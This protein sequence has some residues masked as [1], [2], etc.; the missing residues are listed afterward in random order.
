MPRTASHIAAAA[1]FA[2]AALG[3]AAPVTSAT[4]PAFGY[5]RTE[6]GNAIVEIAACETGACGEMVWLDKP[7]DESGALKRDADGR[8]LCG[9]ELVSGLKRAGHGV[10]EEG[11]ILDPRSGQRYAAEIAVIASDK[12]NVRGYVLSS[13]FGASQVWT[14]AMGD[15]GGC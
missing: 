4:D 12:L 9:L 11:E 5:W 10:W 13:L 14:R 1:V 6:S 8:P 2:L 3:L 15:Q 7:V